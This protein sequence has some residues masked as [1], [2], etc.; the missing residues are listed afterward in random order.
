MYNPQIKKQCKL[1][2]TQYLKLCEDTRSCDL[3][4]C[5]PFA[6]TTLVDSSAV[7]EKG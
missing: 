7:A 3:G 2:K 6:N 5:F 1:V 4:I